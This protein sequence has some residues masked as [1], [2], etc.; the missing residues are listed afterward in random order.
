MGVW[1]LGCIIRLLL[2][3]M[4]MYIRGECEEGQLGHEDKTKVELKPRMVDSLEGM[5]IR[6]VHAGYFHSMALNADV[7]DRPV[8]PAEQA[9]REEL[10]KLHTNVIMCILYV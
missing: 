9:E 3:T 10:E 1:L 7:F 6:Q 4:A 8:P 5:G 2:L